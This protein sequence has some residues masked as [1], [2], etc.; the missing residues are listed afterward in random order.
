MERDG[1]LIVKPYPRPGPG[2]AVRPHDPRAAE[3]AAALIAA[4]RKR[5][6][7]VAAAHVGSSAVP[8][9][10][11]KGY[12][13]LAIA[14]ADGE[15]RA[16]IDAA[17]FALRFGRQGGRDPFPEERPMR[18]GLV[19]WGGAAFPVHAHVL[20]APEFAELV[21]FRDALRA[22]PALVAAYVAEKRRILE[23]GLADG[24]DY[25]ERKGGFIR[26]TLARLAAR[27][28]GERA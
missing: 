20:P 12:V 6:P 10:A 23:V 28:A 24:A 27:T 18:I 3:A 25:A 7:G 2:L 8:G 11:G 4:L 13:D 22:D 9:C 5:V 15:E 14:F 26:Q 21:A 19:E 17:L 16:R 1:G